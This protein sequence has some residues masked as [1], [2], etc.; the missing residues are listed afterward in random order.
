MVLRSLTKTLIFACKKGYE[1][2]NSHGETLFLSIPETCV[3][4]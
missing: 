4:N 2:Y 3:L 1:L